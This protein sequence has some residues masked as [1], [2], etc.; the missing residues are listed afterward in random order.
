M[1]YLVWISMLMLLQSVISIQRRVSECVPDEFVEEEDDIDESKIIA[2]GPKRINVNDKTVATL[3]H[4]FSL[5]WNQNNTESKQFFR[6][7]CIKR[8]TSQV[9]SGVLYNI[10]VALTETECDKEKFAGASASQLYEGRLLNECPY[11]NNELECWFQ[12]VSQ[13]WLDRLE[14][15][16]HDCRFS[17]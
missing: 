17:D 16:A 10:T 1:K 2:G 14:V 7:S 8:G 12:L 5:G 13:P 6:V 3:A 4:H 15:L 9:V 11:T